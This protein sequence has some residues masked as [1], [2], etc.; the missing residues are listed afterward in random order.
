MDHDSQR[1]VLRATFDELAEL[2]DR[3]RPNYPSQLFDD[4][5]V[6]ARLRKGAHLLEIGCGTGQGTTALAERGYRITCVELGEHLSAVASRNLKHF[7][8]VEVINADF[9]AWLPQSGEF[10]A[11]V[12]FTAFHWIAPEVRYQKAASLLR[13][14]GMLGVV[15]T[16]HVLPP[17]GDRFFVEVQDDYEA[18]LP[19]DPATIAGGPRPPDMIPDLSE[20]ISESRLFGSIAARRYLWDVAYTADE[21]IDVLNTYSN[22]R[23][24]APDTRERL[25][26]RIRRRIEARPGR[27]VRKTYLATLNIAERL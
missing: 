26:D 9:E 11:L 22:H 8:H 13:D 23:A 1:R 24:L 20:E 19:D 14:H 18:V 27:R 6:L 12:A 10:D 15:G 2:Y 5:V 4:L 3:S 25:L 16:E 21:Y 7:P 17:D